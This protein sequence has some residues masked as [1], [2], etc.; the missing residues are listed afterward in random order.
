[1]DNLGAPARILR[2]YQVFGRSISRDDASR[3]SDRLRVYAEDWPI[4]RNAKVGSVGYGSTAEKV[5]AA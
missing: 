3:F 1:M 5:T 2:A 4:R